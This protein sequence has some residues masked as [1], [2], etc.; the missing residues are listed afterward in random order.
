VKISLYGS[1][2]LL[3]VLEARDRTASGII[4]PTTARD[5]TP[6]ML[7]EVKAKGQGY[8]QNGV[9]IPLPCE[10][11]DVV[12]FFRVLTPGEQLVFPL[13]DDSPG[14]E[15][16]LIVQFHNLCGA[17]TDFGSHVAGLVVGP[18]GRYVQ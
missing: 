6:W 2:V 17:V 14:R 12:Q 10:V 3:R 15:S 5:G 11:G 16:G 7:G 4:I 9:L 1:R 8:Y 18:D 13:D